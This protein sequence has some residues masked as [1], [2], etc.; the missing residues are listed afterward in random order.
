M[1]LALTSL[2]LAAAGTLTTLAAAQSLTFAQLPAPVQATVT[3]E[4]QGGTIHEIELEKKHGVVFYEVELIV[5]DV[6]YELEI[7]SDGKLLGREVD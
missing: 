3:R 7:A 4:A 5:A 6:K 2:L 1:K